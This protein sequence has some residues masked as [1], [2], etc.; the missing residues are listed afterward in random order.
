MPKSNIEHEFALRGCL[1]PKCREFERLDIATINKINERTA[2]HAVASQ[3]VG[4]PRHDT[5]GFAALNTCHHIIE[6]GTTGSFGRLAL[7]EGAHNLKSLPQG[8]FIKLNFL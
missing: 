5:V 1:K 6:N 8:I 3:T 4:M 2:I 7:A